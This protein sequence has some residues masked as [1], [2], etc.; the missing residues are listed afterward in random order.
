[1][2]LATTWTGTGTRL[3]GVTGEGLLIDIADG[4]AEADDLAGVTDVGDLLRRGPAAATRVAAIISGADIEGRTALADADLAPPVT[5][6]QA[7]VCIGRN[8]MA[9]IEEGGDPVPELPILF[10]KYPNTLVGDRDPVI[11]HAITSALDYEGE[12]ALIIGRRASHVPE[13]EAM[14]YVAGYTVLNDISARDLQLGDVQWIRGK[15]LDTFCPLGPVFVSIDEI[16]DVDALRIQTRVNG[17]LRQDAPV[18]D[19]IFKIPYLISFITE[20]ITLEPGDI[21]AT[22]T[23][24]GVAYGM[25]PRVYLKP[26]D[27]VEVS[28]EGIGTL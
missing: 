6:P 21:V 27:A 16:P 1:M 9:H 13:A 25:N 2:R 22:G 20:G 15:S 18:S 7:I 28:I 3:M 17:E 14:S 12:L 10:S 24:S 19:M 23:P 5:H 4:A 11:H 26:G 8:Y